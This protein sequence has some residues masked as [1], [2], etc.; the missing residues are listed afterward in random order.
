MSEAEARPFVTPEGVDLELTIATAS[1]RMTAFLIDVVIIILSM[2]ALTLGIVFL[3]YFFRFIAK[4][5]LGILWILGFFFLRCFYFLYFEL[6]ARAATPG[7]R[8][9]GLRVAMR[10]GSAL[11]ADT[12]F[13][14]NALREL[15]V[16]LPLTFM[17]AEAN[18]VD[19][20]IEIA[21]LVW[22]AI[23]VFFPLFNRDRLRIGDLVA[24]TWV[25][26]VPKKLMEPDIASSAGAKSMSFSREQ[27]DAYGIKELSVLEDVL[28]RHDSDVMR[29][30]AEKIRTK[31]KMADGDPDEVFLNAYYA[32][33]RH[34]LE[35]RLLLGERKRDK[36]DR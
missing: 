9:L 30:V 32:A 1:E 3:G 29:S 35:S 23:F 2:V 26:H 12:I 17:A 25:V 14:R 8:M 20:W 31:I 21:A 28:R 11:S 13:A 10:D 22:C 33:L 7:K 18:A 24:G 27:L 5:A 15:E 6:S 16:F 34:R 4:E 36:Y 19:G